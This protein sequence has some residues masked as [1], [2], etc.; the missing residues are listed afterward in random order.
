VALTESKMKYWQW[1][2]WFKWYW[3]YNWWGW[4]KNKQPTFIHIINISLF[5]F[6]ATI[7]NYCRWWWTML[8]PLMWT[9]M[10]L[11]CY[12]RY[13]NEAKV[14]EVALTELNKKYGQWWLGNTLHCQ[15]SRLRRFHPRNHMKCDDLHVILR[16]LLHK[17][18]PLLANFERN[19]IATIRNDCRWWWAM[20]VDGDGQCWFHLCEPCHDVIKCTLMKLKS[21]KWR[22]QN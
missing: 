4:G 13:I 6:I 18:L 16:G 1:L 3:S 20:T 17:R 15:W 10:M 5:Y 14:K 9:I 12:Q 11:W 7:R 2:Q 8:V 21:K 22:S 19:F